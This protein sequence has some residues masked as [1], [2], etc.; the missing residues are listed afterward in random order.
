MNEHSLGWVCAR[1]GGDLVGWV[2]VAW[3]GAGHAFVLDTAVAV[4][5]RRRG[6]ASGL[7][8]VAVDE[9]REAGC[10]WL[11]VDFVSELAPLYLDACGFRST[12]AGLLDLR[13]P[14]GAR[15]P[16]QPS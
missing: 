16:E 1:S 10:R 9:S 8:T 7:I 11:H 4:T 3:D 2:N 6:I 13:S 15:V 5:H 14:A 12:A